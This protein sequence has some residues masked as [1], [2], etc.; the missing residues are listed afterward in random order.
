MQKEAEEIFK[1][2]ENKTGKEIMH[3][4][5]LLYMKKRGHPELD[6]LEKYGD[7]LTH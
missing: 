1:E 3:G 7:R 5:G 6:E 4:G 2:V